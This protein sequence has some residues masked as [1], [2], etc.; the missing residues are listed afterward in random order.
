MDD[1][2][3]KKR[4]RNKFNKEAGEQEAREEENDLQ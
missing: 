3:K 1:R 4:S 2:E